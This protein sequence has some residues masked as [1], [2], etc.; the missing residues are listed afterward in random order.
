[1]Q[2]YLQT[3]NWLEYVE[4]ELRTF[5]RMAAQL[6]WDLSVNP[7][8]KTAIQAIQLGIAKHRWK[9]NVCQTKPLHQILSPIQQR[10]IYLLCRGPK[11]SGKM[12]E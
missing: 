9:N 5:N 6:T 11:F 2:D 10:K 4:S 3:E 12:I 8:D 1:M 7:Q